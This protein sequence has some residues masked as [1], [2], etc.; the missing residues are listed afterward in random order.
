MPS[1]G[2]VRKTHRS[3]PRERA[4]GHVKARGTVRRREL[5]APYRTRERR[6]SSHTQS[7]ERRVRLRTVRS[8][9]NPPTSMSR[10]GKRCVVAS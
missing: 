4:E 3:I 6:K 5:D 8:R 10:R 7:V 9:A 1:V 2:C